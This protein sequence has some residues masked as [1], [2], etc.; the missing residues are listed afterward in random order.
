MKKQHNLKKQSKSVVIAQDAPTKP[1]LVSQPFYMQIADGCACISQPG[2]LVS[3]INNSNLPLEKKVF[4][5]A[6]TAYPSDEQEVKLSVLN[7]SQPTSSQSF[8]NASTDIMYIPI[9]DVTK[10]E[11][12]YDESS[13]AVGDHVTVDFS[14]ISLLASAS[15]KVEAAAENTGDF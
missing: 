12:V 9:R 15:A 3:V 8:D 10:K 7:I 4:T 6:S 13:M 11:S 2:T 1:T 5:V 14:A